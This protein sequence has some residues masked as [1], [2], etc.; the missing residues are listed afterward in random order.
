MSSKE[1]ITLDNMTEKTFHLVLWIL[2]FGRLGVKWQQMK[3]L[4]KNVWGT[5][6]TQDHFNCIYIYIKT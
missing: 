6:E 4:G 1:L 3:R 5:N 2:M